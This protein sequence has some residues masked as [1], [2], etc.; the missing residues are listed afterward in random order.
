VRDV[1]RGILRGGLMRMAMLRISMRRNSFL[2]SMRKERTFIIVMFRRG[3]RFLCFG[4][5]IMI[6]VSFPNF[7]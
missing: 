5:K 2:S 6:S 4:L 1:A 3:G 7:I